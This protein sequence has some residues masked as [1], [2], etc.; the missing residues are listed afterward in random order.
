MAIKRYKLQK[1]ISESLS[2][3]LYNGIDTKTGD[4]ISMKV[5]KTMDCIGDIPKKRMHR[6][7]NAVSSIASPYVS[8]HIELIETSK[9]TA[10]VTPRETGVS[11][12]SFMI[13]NH[14][15]PFGTLITIAVQI[16]KGLT[17][18][19]NKG[20]V[21]R[22]LTP[23]SVIISK[24]NAVSLTGFGMASIEN[25]ETLTMTGEI[26]GE[27]DY[28]PPET[29]LAASRDLRVDIY[30]FG[31]ILWEMLTGKN[32][33]TGKSISEIIGMKSTG[34]IPLPS[35]VKGK[36]PRWLDELVSYCIEAS[37]QQRP[38]SFSEI[39]F[40]LNEKQRPEGQWIKN[41][42]GR[43]F[44][45]GYRL[46]DKLSFCHFCGEA[47]RKELPEDETF[48][49]AIQKTSNHNKT[50]DF[51]KNTIALSP[52]RPLKKALKKTPV[53]IIEGVSKSEGHWFIEELQKTGA[54]A[55]ITSLSVFYFRLSSEIIFLM[56]F[57][58]FVLYDTC[59]FFYLPF[60]SESHL[61][62]ISDREELI[63][64]Q[65]LR[66][67]II[68]FM[69]YLCIRM[70]IV[71]RKHY[72]SIL[73]IPYIWLKGAEDK[74]GGASSGLNQTGTILR[75]IGTL[76]SFIIIG[77]LVY[78]LVL[79]IIRLVANT[80]S[81]NHVYDQLTGITG[82]LFNVNT[83]VNQFFASEINYHTICINQPSEYLPL[84]SLIA[85][86][87][88][89]K[90]VVGRNSN[91]KPLYSLAAVNQKTAGAVSFKSNEVLFK[92]LKKSLKEVRHVDFR[93]LTADAIESFLLFEN[94][95]QS[96]SKTLWYQE[97]KLEVTEAIIRISKTGQGIKPLLGAMT[98]ES[99]LKG[100]NKLKNIKDTI[101]HAPQPIPELLK[102]RLRNAQ[103][104]LFTVQAAEDEVVELLN[105]FKSVC[106]SLKTLILQAAKAGATE[107]DHESEE[108]KAEI[109]ILSEELK[110]LTAYLPA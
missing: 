59:D 106:G 90:M 14:P 73:K 9:F 72:A 35:M 27:I 12:S 18:C 52:K 100:E 67:L 78:M 21:H 7:F 32:P 85:L 101:K 33:F 6:E 49:L 70:I 93:Y 53:S 47:I 41:N 2:F 76:V 95:K 45:C 31:I 20:V 42:Q 74:S 108:L 19:H 110:A 55:S 80:F 109:R 94:L 102:K 10:I 69:I 34:A 29:L 107:S 65:E 99:L 43:C 36:I 39:I 54:T 44:S 46:T 89:V 103:D 25:V 77:F 16:A 88:I 23:S 86:L 40:W 51:L 96:F 1:K 98:R 91:K 71:F 38:V 15:V 84:L 56:M 63:W 92:N 11:L 81:K 26:F 97:L 28:S 17:A 104:E 68:I 58:L 50:A 64:K 62:L 79:R 8:T 3:D 83:G 24:D 30:S 60:A 4:P 61:L 66:L 37:P 87:I 105:Y 22:N 48:V 82:T 75:L 5:L 13:M 57:F